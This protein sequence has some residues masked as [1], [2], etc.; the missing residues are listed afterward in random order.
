MTPAKRLKA[1]E[2]YEDHV[3]D[4]GHEVDVAYYCDLH[5]VWT[6]GLRCVECGP[7]GEMNFVVNKD[8]EYT[9]WGC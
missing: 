2:V 5:E 1:T 3:S 8:Q 9:G 7:D 4:L 6:E